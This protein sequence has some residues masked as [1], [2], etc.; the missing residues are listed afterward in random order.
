MSTRCYAVDTWQGDSQ[1][2][3]YTDEVLE[4]LKA[5]H[6]PRYAL[7][8]KLIRSTFDDAVSLFEDGSVDLLHI[9]G[10]HAYDSVKHDFET[11]LPKLSNRGVV[12]FHD[13][14]VRD[15]D[16]FGVWRFWD[17]LKQR[18]P[19]FEFL[20]SH[21]L[22]VIAVGEFVLEELNSLLYMSVNE[23]DLIRKYFENLGNTLVNLNNIG[24]VNTNL[25][26]LILAKTEEWERLDSERTR[27]EVRAHEIERCGRG[28]ECYR[29][30]I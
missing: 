28:T 18:Y 4:N 1:A 13:T 11:W 27:V 9:D 22:G 12:L 16:G 20:H 25:N 19:S 10:Y 21:G 30:G 14:E 8:S 15:Q 5:H 7:F 29:R 6:D 2:A 24:I 26:E 23:I 17:E 3:F